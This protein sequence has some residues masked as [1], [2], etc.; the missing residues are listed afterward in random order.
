MKGE[1][2]VAPQQRKERSQRRALAPLQGTARNRGDEGMADAGGQ[3]AGGGDSSAMRL[4]SEMSSLVEVATAFST[5][6]A[7]RERAAASL[8]ADDA[9]HLARA[10]EAPRQPHGGAQVQDAM[11][12]APRRVA[13]ST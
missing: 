2:E 7:A 10:Q 12:A 6:Y 4:P 9:P 11:C 13:R 3:G 5:E 8:C 1:S